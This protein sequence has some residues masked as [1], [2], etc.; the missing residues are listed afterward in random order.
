VS[1]VSGTRTRSDLSTLLDTATTDRGAG[2]A[3][4]DALAALRSLVLG[5]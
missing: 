3:A 4:A 2:V 1:T 5:F